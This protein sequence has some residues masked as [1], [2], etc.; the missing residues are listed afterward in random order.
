[1]ISSLRSWPMSWSDDSLMCK[2]ASGR[3][4]PPHHRERD[5]IERRRGPGKP[6]RRIRSGQRERATAGL[7]RQREPVQAEMTSQRGQV[8][9]P[10]DQAAF[11]LVTGA[12]VAGL[13]QR[14]PAQAGCPGRLVIPGSAQARHRC[15]RRVE[16][17]CP[18]RSPNSCQLSRLPSG[19]VITSDVTHTSRRFI[20]GCP[21]TPAL[22]RGWGAGPAI[23]P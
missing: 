2:V 19:R 13:V 22:P 17:R 10:T 20:A 3:Q 6:A 18:S 11:R 5:R 14:D 21:R 8:I 12:A 7:A 23:S 15:P 1:M 4:R 9:S 16:S